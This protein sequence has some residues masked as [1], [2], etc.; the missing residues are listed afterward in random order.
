MQHPLP[1]WRQS[2]GFTLIELMVTVSV[3]AILLGLGVPGFQD[4]VARS[5]A[6]SSSSE[7]AGLL[8]LARQEAIKRGREVRVS[9]AGSVATDW[10]LGVR[11]VAVEGASEVE[12]RTVGSFSG[13]G[14]ASTRQAGIVASRSPIAFL[15]NGYLD[16]NPAQVQIHFGKGAS[17]LDGKERTLC[18]SSV[19][20]VRVIEGLVACN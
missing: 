19:G 10:G 14:T 8:A 3:L 1:L 16:G 17:N 9:G 13:V 12:V 20:T 4:F 18:L 7:I 11:V 15:P 5:Q 2:A 6:R